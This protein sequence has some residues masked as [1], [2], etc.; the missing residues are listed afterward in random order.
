MS[1]LLSGA[2]SLK[3]KPRSVFAAAASNS[4][5]RVRQRPRTAVKAVAGGLRT[6]KSSKK[7]TP[8]TAKQSSGKK[9]T[10]D[11]KEADEERR[12]I[13]SGW[14]SGGDFEETLLAQA[15][16]SNKK[17]SQVRDTPKRTPRRNGSPGENSG[18]GGDDGAQQ[19]IAKLAGLVAGLTEQMQML[20]MEVQVDRDLRAR[21]QLKQ[22]GGREGGREGGRK[23]SKKA[24][25]RRGRPRLPLV[26]ESDSDEASE[27]TKYASDSGD[28]SSSS[29]S[30]E[31]G[32][33]QRSGSRR[34]S[35]RK[36]EIARN[37]EDGILE[38]D[39]ETRR[40][41]AAMLHKTGRRVSNAHS[42]KLSASLSCLSAFGSTTT[43]SSV[44]DL[45]YDSQRSDQRK[46]AKA[47]LVKAWASRTAFHD[48]IAAQR[49]WHSRSRDNEYLPLLYHQAEALERKYG[50]PASKW[51]LENRFT[52]KADNPEK[53]WRKVIGKLKSDGTYFTSIPVDCRSE[54]A[55]AFSPKSGGGPSGG[56]VGGPG[57]GGGKAAG[58]GRH[59]EHP[60]F[61]GQAAKYVGAAKKSAT[62]TEHCPHHNSWFK[63]N[64]HTPCY[65]AHGKDGVH[66][67]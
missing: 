4:R 42:S 14:A 38:M 31:D 36:E 16:T 12:R 15:L 62:N 63:P 57:K 28:S 40:G 17:A 47:A 46:I 25:E 29:D 7:K 27:E 54:L 35:R 59:G 34:S 43:R 33:P 9:K 6:P 66:R 50:W 10:K 37:L 67:R 21:K 19:Q 52:Y 30:S 24:E 61:P 45:L 49:G 64:T 32:F 39:H 18:P 48:F 58:F 60:R 20:R 22:P 53:R 3:V 51:Y 11:M 8:K 23:Q 1:K 26:S 65:H 2:E 5:L 56:T 55:A 41:L 13:L 44:E